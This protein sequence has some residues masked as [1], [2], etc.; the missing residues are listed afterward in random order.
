[1]L[2]FFVAV[3]AVLML[4]GCS[5]EAAPAP[6][7]DAVVATENQVASVIAEYEQPWRE[8]A[9][10]SGECRIVWAIDSKEDPV[11]NLNGAS[12]YL[13][14]QTASITAKLA[15]DDL[16]AMNVPPSME[17]LVSKTI[18]AL[19]PVAAADLE[20]V[21]GADVWPVETDE[22]NLALAQN[23]SSLNSLTTAL[24]AWKPYL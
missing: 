15:T 6:T 5:A 23:F 11:A 20:S 4:V 22:C 18:A 12:C 16:K 24:D 8:V 17:S 19:D 13:A 7:A 3:P 2:K 14:E 10:K 1:M 21:C 9:D